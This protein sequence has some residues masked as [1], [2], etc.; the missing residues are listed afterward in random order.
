MSELN[1][2][3]PSNTAREGATKKEKYTTKKVPFQKKKQN[4]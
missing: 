1:A 4:V 2:R 3:A